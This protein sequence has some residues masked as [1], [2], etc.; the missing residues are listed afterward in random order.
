VLPGSLNVHGNYLAKMDDGH[1]GS[2]HVL[3]A[4]NDQ[5]G[6]GEVSADSPDFEVR[7][8]AIS[9]TLSNGPPAVAAAAPIQ[10]STGETKWRLW[11]MFGGCALVILTLIL[12]GRARQ[13]AE[14]KSSP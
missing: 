4:A 7:L 9:G 6:D 2:I 5:I 11:A 13:I 12:R 1:V 8:P 10:K 3:N 14:H